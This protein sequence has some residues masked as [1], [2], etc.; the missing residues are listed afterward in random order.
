MN[1]C[2]SAEYKLA[3]RENKRLS[4]EYKL[5]VRENKRLPA[6]NFDCL[7]ESACGAGCREAYFIGMFIDV[8]AYNGRKDRLDRMF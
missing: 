8:P 3:V 1:I 6:E 5:A 7:R 4:A 2:L